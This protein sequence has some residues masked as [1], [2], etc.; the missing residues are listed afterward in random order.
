MG[1]SLVIQSDFIAKLITK[2]IKNHDGYLDCCKIQHYPYQ[3]NDGT[4]ETWIQSLTQVKHTHLLALVNIH[5]NR[6]PNVL[7]LSPNIFSHPSLICLF[8]FGYYLES[9]HAFN[10]CHNLTTL[11][12]DKIYVEVGVFNTV[13]ASCPSLKVL[14]IDITWYNPKGCLKIHHNNLKLLH[15]ACTY[16]DF[17]DVSTPLLDILA[18]QCVLVMRSNFLLRAP[19]ILG[20]KKDHWIL[21]ESIPH[22]YYNVSSDAQEI[23]NNWHEFMVNKYTYD[24]MR[25]KTLAVNVDL[26][27]PR[28]VSML[29]D[30]CDAWST[31]MENLEIFF[32]RN[33]VLKEEGESSI[34]KAQ[35][36]KSK[37]RSFFFR[38]DFRVRVVWM[39][40]LGDF[41]KEEFALAS[42]L[43][44]Q[45]TVTYK[46]MIETSSIPAN[47]KLKI[48]VAM[49]KLMDLSKGNK[50][51]IIECF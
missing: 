39:Y 31:N 7:Q 1:D 11:K 47:K 24:L 6:G 15:L 18:I 20:L 3:T 42:V 50:E 9:A 46:L 22:I 43:V 19:R 29:K 30:V 8:L 45:E 44:R 12:L 14:V 2:V 25:F 5:G 41:D 27:N 10:N 4:L 34:G 17:I 32:K 28:E 40:N 21:D 35:E 51:L 33:N 49:A 36:K 16:I 38:A 48:E 26:K 23:E 13:I 37:E